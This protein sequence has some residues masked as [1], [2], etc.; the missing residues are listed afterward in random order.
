MYIQSTVC[1]NVTIQWFCTAQQIFKTVPSIYYGKC[2]VFTFSRKISCTFLTSVSF[3]FVLYLQGSFRIIHLFGTKRCVSLTALT[4]LFEMKC[5]PGSDRGSENTPSCQ[6]CSLS[7]LCPLNT[8][9]F[10]AA[11]SLIFGTKCSDI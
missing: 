1:Q 9:W 10:R 7:V 11:A 4:L 6:S 3:L 5:L 2:N 8:K